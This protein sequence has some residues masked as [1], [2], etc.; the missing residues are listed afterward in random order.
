M[1]V[2]KLGPKFLIISTSEK[3]FC[4]IYFGNLSFS[5]SSSSVL[6]G[7]AASV[8]LSVGIMLKEAIY[9]KI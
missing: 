3:P 6:A 2:I 5:L 7:K 9:Y 8:I 1:T 4:E